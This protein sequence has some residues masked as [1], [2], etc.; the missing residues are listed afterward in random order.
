M[1]A[2]E[3]EQAGVEVTRANGATAAS[4]I[5]EFDFA[6]SVP[7]KN[8]SNHEV[9]KACIASKKTLVTSK[10]AAITIAKC[11]KQKPFFELVSLNQANEQALAY[12]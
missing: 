7:Q 4:L 5:N 3:F 9:R 10:F 8:D 2:K 12:A 1:I 6:V 11:L